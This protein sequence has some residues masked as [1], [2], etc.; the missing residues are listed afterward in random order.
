MIKQCE[1]RQSAMFSVFYNGSDESIESL[2]EL[3][4]IFKVDCDV[5]R[6]I[7]FSEV[8]VIT[9]PDGLIELI[10]NNRYVIFDSGTRSITTVHPEE[11][12]NTF[13]EFTPDI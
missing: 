8:V 7:F 3:L 13:N 4:K 9:R 5:R 6:H 11:Y 10:F 2:S 12:K 1:R